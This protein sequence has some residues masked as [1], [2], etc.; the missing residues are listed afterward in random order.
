M[1]NYC[2][3]RTGF[4]QIAE[5]KC[6]RRDAEGR[7]MLIATDENQMDTDQNLISTQLSVS[8][9]IHLWQKLNLNSS[10]F[11]STLSASSA[12]AFGF[13]PTSAVRIGF[14]GMMFPASHVRQNSHHSRRHSDGSGDC[15]SCAIAG[16]GHEKSV[17]AVA[18]CRWVGGT[19]VRAG[20]G[21]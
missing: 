7:Q 20:R 5:D 19:D 8:I 3:K 17:G 10:A 16:A 9:G 2:V 11:V 13:A 21:Q 4:V 14:A 6:N 18:R 1:I 15:R 12:V